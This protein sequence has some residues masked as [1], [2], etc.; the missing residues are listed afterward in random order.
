MWVRGVDLK[1][2]EWEDSQANEFII[3]D[4]GMSNLRPV[5]ERTGYDE[6]YQLAADMGGAG[7]TFTGDNDCDI[8]LN[9]MMININVIDGCYLSDSQRVFY[10]SS[11]CVY[12]D[13]TETYV[14]S[15]AYPANP[16][17]EYG[18]EKLFAERL[19]LAA[20]RN[21]GLE[22][23]IARYHNI[24][25]PQGTWRGGREK[26]VAALCRKI[27]MAKDGEEIEV[28]GDGNQLRSFLHVNECVEGTIRLMRSEHTGPFNIGS[29]FMV[30]VRTLF[31][32][33]AEIAGKQVTPRFVPGPVG[34]TRRTSDNT[35]IR[36]ALGWSPAVPSH[37]DLAENYRWIEEQVRLCG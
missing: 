14:E 23:R 12:P 32:T 28:W 4:L 24:F 17:S 1:R 20:G 35:A 21:Y 33:L 31:Y 29:S 25:G 8:M 6:V 2:P 5:F 27:A 18:W 37:Y 13:D 9:S 11:A 26:V 16:G 10:A 15:A 34:T 30:D 3:Q 19:Y 22:P 7:F 36:E